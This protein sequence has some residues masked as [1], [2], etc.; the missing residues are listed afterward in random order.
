MTLSKKD[1]TNI[2]NILS[3]NIEKKEKEKL[4]LE[5]YLKSK[6]KIN[7]KANKISL[8]KKYVSTKDIE[9]SKLIIAPKE[10]TNKTFELAKEK[11]KIQKIFTIRKDIL[12]T[13]ISYHKSSN[14][15]ELLYY[16]LFVS[17][18]RFSN[19][20]SGEF[21]NTK[22]RG[23]ISAKLLKKRGDGTFYKFPLIG[24]KQ[25]FFKALKRFRKLYKT[26]KTTGAFNKQAN[27]LIKHK[28]QSNEFNVSKLR[29]LYALWL[30][31][32]KNKENIIMPSFISNVLC[33]SND[34][35]SIH[36]SGLEIVN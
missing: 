31:K 28:L 29:P 32:H 8:T 20:I 35:C 36:Y 3:R 14:V 19:I 6:L 1:M 30:F 9:L 18:R 23:I 22:N 34:S 12:D 10:L 21:Q 26:I 13:L 24:T 11:R 5:L 2:D 7:S 15:Y 4:I 17:G 33:H 27:L 16:L 25:K